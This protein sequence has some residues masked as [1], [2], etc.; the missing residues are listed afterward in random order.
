M[1]EY[2]KHAKIYSIDDS[3][4]STATV[5]FGVAR[6]EIMWY[7]HWDSGTNIAGSMS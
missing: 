1:E 6:I 4:T 2:G 7:S 3:T 5:T